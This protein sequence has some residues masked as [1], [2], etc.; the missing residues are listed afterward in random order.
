MI[1]YFYCPKEDQIFV[2]LESALVSLVVTKNS[3]MLLADLGGV[4]YLRDKVLLSTES[5]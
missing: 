1:K 5:I 4:S 3:R 2:L